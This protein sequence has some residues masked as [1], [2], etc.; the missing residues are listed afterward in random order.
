MLE[1]IMIL[2]SPFSTLSKAESLIFN[3]AKALTINLFLTI[4]K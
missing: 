3:S 4:C 2:E 1:A